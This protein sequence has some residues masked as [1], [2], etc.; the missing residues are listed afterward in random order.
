MELFEGTSCPPGPPVACQVVVGACTFGRSLRL[1]ATAGQSYLLRI[2]GQTDLAE[3][4]TT[5]TVSPFVPPANDELAGA[6]VLPSDEGIYQSEMKAVYGGSSYD[7]DDPAD[8]AEY[9]D[10]HWRRNQISDHFPVWCE[11]IVDSSDEFLTELKAT[12]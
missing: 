9:Y 4:T 1:F 8:L 10:L 3:G 5:L 7:L 11:L 6:F 2:G 12:T